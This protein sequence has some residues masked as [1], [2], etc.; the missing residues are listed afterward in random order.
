M[1]PEFVVPAIEYLLTELKL[2]KYLNLE[3]FFIL[4]NALGEVT[5]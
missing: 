5:L 4:H 1:N 2:S 3:S